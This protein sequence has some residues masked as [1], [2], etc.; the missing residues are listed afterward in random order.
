MAGMYVSHSV[1][2]RRPFPECARALGAEPEKWFPRLVEGMS[3]VGPVVAGVPIRKRVKV[4]VGETSAAG[5]WL[6][7]PIAWTPSSASHLFPSMEGKLELVPVDPEET[8]LNISGTYAAPL[9]GA[10]SQLDEVMMHRVAEDTFK[11]LAE[12]IAEKIER[13]AGAGSKT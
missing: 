3:S 12:A 10:G 9:G 8:R 11:E 2:I 4:T 6:T 13:R 1:H 7:V 5:S